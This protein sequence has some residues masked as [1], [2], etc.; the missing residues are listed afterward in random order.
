MS[1]ANGKLLKLQITISKRTD[2]VY[3]QDIPNG[4]QLGDHFDTGN[5]TKSTA[6]RLQW[7]K[8]N[9]KTLKI[10]QST[11]LCQLKGSCNI[12]SQFGRVVDILVFKGRSVFVCKM[13]RTICFYR[14]LQAFK[15]RARDGNLFIVCPLHKL[16]NWHTYTLHTPA[17]Q[18]PNNIE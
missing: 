4:G 3:L 8:I 10:N 16:V 9:S 12:Y 11:V 14:H 15:V 5:V 17:F 6:K 7:M 2:S 13:F 1:S 18:R